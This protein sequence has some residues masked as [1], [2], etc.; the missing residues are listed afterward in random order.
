ML[1]VLKNHIVDV[2]LYLNLLPAQGVLVPAD[3]CK[4]LLDSISHQLDMFPEVLELWQF[5]LHCN[6][7]QEK[8]K[9]PFSLILR[10]QELPLHASFLWAAW[11]RLST[12]T[13]HPQ[14]F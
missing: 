13:L 6:Q 3:F 8:K 1:Q 9:K 12:C 11:L 2:G 14:M 10:L 7:C 4:V 5:Q